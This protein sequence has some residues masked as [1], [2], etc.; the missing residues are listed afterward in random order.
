MSI[1]YVFS[2]LFLFATENDVKL[3]QLHHDLHQTIPIPFIHSI[4]DGNCD[5]YY[6]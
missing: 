6:G 3:F 2:L 1:S 5:L 4:Y